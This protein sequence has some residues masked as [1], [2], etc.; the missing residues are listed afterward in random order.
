M[1][2]PGI[3]GAGS[4]E[5]ADLNGFRSRFLGM[6]ER[7]IAWLIRR[8]QGDS[9]HPA[10]DVGVAVVHVWEFGKSTDYVTTRELVT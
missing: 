6:R 2:R 4:L 9:T 1:S 5:I 7:M 8:G 10:A 3:P